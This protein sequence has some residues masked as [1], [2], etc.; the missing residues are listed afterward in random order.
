MRLFRISKNPTRLMKVQNSNFP[1]LSWG[2]RPSVTMTCTEPSNHSFVCSL[3]V[4]T[5]KSKVRLHRWA[6]IV[7][8]HQSYLGLLNPVY[9]TVAS[10][11]TGLQIRRKHSF[12]VDCSNLACTLAMVASLFP[13]KK[14]TCLCPGKQGFLGVA[15]CL[16]YI[17]LAAW[18]CTCQCRTA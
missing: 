10:L 3:L 7:V 1:T 13:E 2:Q 16:T 5:S 15:M 14:E 6:T 8:P 18:H 17:L 9:S 11:K 4:H 12:Q